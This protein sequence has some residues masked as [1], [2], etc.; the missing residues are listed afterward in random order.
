M[1]PKGTSKPTMGQKCLSLRR[2]HVKI[3]K[4]NDKARICYGACQPCVCCDTGMA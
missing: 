4:A 3:I 1:K 2:D